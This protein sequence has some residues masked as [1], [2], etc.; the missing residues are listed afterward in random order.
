MAQDFQPD[1]DFYSKVAA[2]R[3]GIAFWALM[4][5]RCLMDN[6]WELTESQRSRDYLQ[7]HRS[8]GCH[9]PDFIQDVMEFGPERAVSSRDLTA[10]YRLWCQR[11]AVDPRKDKTLLL[12]IGDNEARL[13]VKK[14]NHIPSDGRQVRGYMGMQA[15][16]EW[17]N[18]GR[19]TLT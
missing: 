16:K 1:R 2:E 8:Q 3:D 6:G 7:S 19:I 4:G 11:N 14:S 18:G 17:R 12:W 10:A 9:F 5:L 15:K 13:G